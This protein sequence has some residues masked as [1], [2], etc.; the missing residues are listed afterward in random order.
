MENQTSYEEL[1]LSWLRSKQGDVV[2]I[3]ALAKKFKVG[4]ASML[5][6][7]N[8]LVASGKVRRSIATRRVGYYVPTEEALATERATE[9]AKPRQAHKI[10]KQRT[11]LYARLAAERA[12]IPSIG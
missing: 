10:D 2:L 6:L 9:A 4:E 11:E 3:P 12:N 1:V 7:M 5:T 8:E